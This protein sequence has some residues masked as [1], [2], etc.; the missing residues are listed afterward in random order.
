[1]HLQTWRQSIKTALFAVLTAQDAILAGR[2]QLD[3][4]QIQQVTF[5]GPVGTK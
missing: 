4:A 2:Y 3:T 1:M 5:G